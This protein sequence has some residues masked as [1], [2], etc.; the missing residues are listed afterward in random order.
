MEDPA[1]VVGQPSHDPVMFVGSL[2]IS[3]GVDDF[4]G[5]NGAFDGVEEFDELP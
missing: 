2:V 5:Q 4:A 1:T 3:D